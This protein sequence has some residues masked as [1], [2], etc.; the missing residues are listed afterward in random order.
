[1][2][3][4]L[5][6]DAWICD[7]HSTGATVTKAKQCQWTTHCYARKD[8]LDQNLSCVAAV[9]SLPSLSSLPMITTLAL[10]LSS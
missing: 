4:L 5:N 3:M 9:F 7:Q 6:T 1:M 2:H 8:S 10:L